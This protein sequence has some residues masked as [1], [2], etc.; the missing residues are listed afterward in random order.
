MLEALEQHRPDV[1]INAA[2]YTAVD[3]AENDKVAAYLLNNAAASVLAAEAQ[4]YGYY[5]LPVSYTHLPLKSIECGNVVAFGLVDI[6]HIIK[7]NAQA[8]LP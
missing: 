7:A 2:A 6:T 8:P 1:V 5:L 4:H 3:K